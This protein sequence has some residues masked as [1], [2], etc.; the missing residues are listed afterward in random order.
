M[1]KKDYLLAL[2]ERS[3]NPMD[4]DELLKSKIS[5]RK[6]KE[7]E[8]QEELDEAT[9][10]ARLAKAKKET[11]TSEAAVEKSGERQEGSGGIRLTGTINYPEML[12][13][14]IA[15]RDNLRVEAEQAAANQQQ[16]SENLRERLHASELLVMK[17]GFEAQMQ[18]LGKLIESNATKGGIVEQLTAARALAEEIGYQKGTPGGG[19]EMIQVEL[20]KLDFEQAIALR[21]LAKEDK[22]EERRWQMEIR[23]LDDE[24][25]VA[26][27][28]LAQEEKKM[29]FLNQAPNVLGAAIGRGIAEAG[30]ID[31]PATISRKAKHYELPVPMGQGGNTNCPECQ[32]D[33]GV[34]P[35]ARTAVCAKCET[36]IS[37]KRV[38]PEG[39]AER[40]RGGESAAGQSDEE[41]E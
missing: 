5:E 19:S 20:K 31:A 41:E 13:K 32:A 28:K 33:V 7:I 6:R 2:G 22:A 16:I 9:H 29:A 23:R 39:S 11:A 10:D 1:L 8:R 15:D 4:T 37:I 25:E 21:K 3:V 14:Q 27:A 36:K 40:V 38:Q 30:G 35:T 24:R 34:G 12:E 17:T 26:K 18:M